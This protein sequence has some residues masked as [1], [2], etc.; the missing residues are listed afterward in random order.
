MTIPLSVTNGAA[1]KNAT[2]VIY[3]IG[4]MVFVPPYQ[5]IKAEYGTLELFAALMVYLLALR[6][7]A[8]RLGR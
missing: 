7:V 2:G 8:T 1:R 5:W 6:V 3:L 4:V